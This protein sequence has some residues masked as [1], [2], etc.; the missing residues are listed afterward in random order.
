MQVP[1][2]FLVM[3]IT[4]IN[5]NMSTVELVERRIV[6]L[7][8]VFFCNGNRDARNYVVSFNWHLYA[9]VLCAVKRCSKFR[10]PQHHIRLFSLLISQ[11]FYWVF[12][13]FINGWGNCFLHNRTTTISEDIFL[14]NR[15]RYRWGWLIRVGRER[16]E[17]EW[18]KGGKDRDIQWHSSPKLQVGLKMGQR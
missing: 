3:T 8:F 15:R 2:D 12:K 1:N 14:K 17:L 4:I 16:L 5:R 18:E 13:N 6:H 11:P 7:D 10:P 9:S